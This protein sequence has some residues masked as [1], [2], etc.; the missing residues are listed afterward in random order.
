M[1][2]ED[3]EDQDRL[4]H[5]IAPADILKLFKWESLCEEL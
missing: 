4:L 2:E 3:L 5:Y 1:G